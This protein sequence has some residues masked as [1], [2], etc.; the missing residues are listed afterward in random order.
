MTR[1]PGNRPRTLNLA[2]A[3][4]VLATLG[5]CSGSEA[6]PSAQSAQPGRSW[7][8]REQRVGDLRRIASTEGDRLLLST[9]G[10][11]ADFVPGVNVGATVPGH[12]PG[13]LAVPRTEYRRWFRDIAALGLRSVR[14]Y[15]IHPPAFYDELA[16][17]NRAHADGPLY[18]VQ[19]VYLSDDDYVREGDLFAPAVEAA[20][21]SELTDAS[22]AVHGELDRPARP[23][24]ASGRWRADVS[25]WVL[26]YVVG[27]ELDP[28]TVVA[29]DQRNAARPAVSG[30]YFTSR[31][32]ATP[33]E[34]WLA[35]MLDHLATEEAGRGWTMPLAFVN[36]PTT[37]P[38]R[39]P[40]EPRP[41]EDLVG[42]D[43]NNLAP[44]PAW[45]GGYFAA[46]HAYP[47]YP[48]FLRYEPGLNAHRYRG[49]PDPYA[50][51]LAALKAHHAAIPVVI[52]EFGVP[53][54]VGSAHRGALGR[55]QGGH[56][57]HDAMQ[58]DA[59]MLTMIKDLGLAGGFVFE[60]QDEWFKQAWNTKDRQQPA[61]RRAL[62]HDAWTNE[63]H[64][65]LQ[66][67]EAAGRGPLRY[68][69]R[70]TGAVREVTATHDATYIHVRVRLADAAAAGSTDLAL[71]FDVVP[72]DGDGLPGHPG[73]PPTADYALSISPA[74]PA[75]LWV[76]AANDPE[77][78][79]AGGGASGW[80]PVRLL[81]NGSSEAKGRRPAIA[82]E[83][84]DVGRLVSGSFDH[85]S[86]AFDSRAA[87][88]VEGAE[89]ELRLPWAA[90][91]MSDPSSRHALVLA[92]TGALGA[93]AVPGIGISV[94]AA[95]APAVGADYGWEPWDTVEWK[96]RPKAGL[97]RFAAAVRAVQ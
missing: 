71:G 18:L 50:G 38:L 48:D 43:A 56:A 78:A 77:A 32:G 39:H 49:R 3:A 37:D 13:E 22:R 36:W 86:S 2:L 91:G 26:A 63:Q 80:N 97:D 57:E 44:T 27:S 33:T 83:H 25:G 82:I 12:Y 17:F 60:W 62:W 85:D 9:A 88:R 70:G 72:G 41:S 28:A 58:M 35:G 5:A 31:P 7:A 30:A 53:S 89:V 46:Y 8:P 20:F 64:Y 54:S 40:E 94:V 92:P 66:A 14:I 34:R 84:Q 67:V 90:V 1:R 87:W 96:A 65:G 11:V 74:G 19:G 79:V 42:I 68:L 51:Y 4:L 15:T 21:R 75:Q 10:G 45:P 52:A 55:D 61:D 6:P 47:N 81:L 76:R 95:G 59:D 69:Y 16:A 73:V 23:G 24:A 29:S 93:V